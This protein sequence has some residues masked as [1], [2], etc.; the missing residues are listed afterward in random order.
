M[1]GDGGF[2]FTIQELATAVE[3]R[4]PIVIVLWHNDGYGEIRDNFERLDIPLIGVDLE[5]PDFLTVARGFGCNAKRAG[6]LG[7]FRR[8]LQN[9]LEA[10][11]PTLLEI[12]PENFAWQ[13]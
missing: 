5:M 2:L 7:E 1:V 13:D 8:L 9:G 6:N 10:D 12:Q 4:L 11:R 3:H